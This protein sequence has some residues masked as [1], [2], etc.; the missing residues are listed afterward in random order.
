MAMIPYDRTTAAAYRTAGE[1]PR[2]GLAWWRKAVAPYVGGAE[3]I[4][5]VGAGT[6]AFATAFAEWFDVRVTAVDPS[7]QMRALIPAHPL[8]DVVAG[9]AESLPVADDAADAAWISTAIHHLADLD[10]AARELRRV[11]CLGAPVLIRDVFPGRHEGV[12][13]FQYF[14]EAT[15]ALSD[16]PTVERVCAAFA[17]AGFER[18][19]SLGL[20]P[21]QTAPSLRVAA[22]RIHREA[23]T[24]LRR[25]SDE[26]FAR[27]MSR[28]WASAAAEDPPAPVIDHLDLLVLC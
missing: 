4:I 9:T 8:V 7:P 12:R 15:K 5:D 17:D 20:V 2:E 10:A 19:L 13:L 6:G 23:N 3:M 24:V 25:L 14:P 22:E 28:M 11:L 1:V 27:G 16:F 18:V 26:E 21:Q